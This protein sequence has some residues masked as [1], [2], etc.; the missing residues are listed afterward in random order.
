MRWERAHPKL[1]E[2][3]PEATTPRRG[4]IK[5]RAWWA[6]RGSNPHAAHAAPAPKAG[7]SAIPPLARREDSAAIRK[8]LPASASLETNYAEVVSRWLDGG[9]AITAP[10]SA[11]DPTPSLR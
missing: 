4:R 8:S 11:R 5:V 9:G 10:S 6:R 1:R 2:R 3:G 7:A